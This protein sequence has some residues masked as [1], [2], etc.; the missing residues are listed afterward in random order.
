MKCR[1]CSKQL[2]SK[3]LDLGFAPHS[4]AYLSSSDLMRHEKYYPLQIYVCENCWLVQTVGETNCEELFDED[5]SYFSS[6]SKSWL[7]HASDYCSMIAKRLNLNKHSNVVEI[8]SNDGY[9]LKNFLQDNI[10]CYG[11]EP[12]KSTADA[13]RMLGIDVIQ[14]F[15]TEALAKEL[16]ISRGK[17]N[18]IIGNNVYA[19]VPDIRDFTRGLKELLAD[20]GTITLEFPHLL[21]LVIKNQFDTIYHEHYSYLSL[22]VVARIFTDAG[23]KII[24]VEALPTHGG[25][26]R[27]YGAHLNDERVVSNQYHEL[28]SCEETNCL[29]SLEA[30]KKLQ[31]EATRLKNELLFFLLECFRNNKKVFAYGAAAKGNTLLNFAGIKPDFLPFICDAAKSKQSKYMPGSHI[32]IIDPAEI[33]IQKPDYILILPWNISEEIIEQI[34]YIR[35]W[36]GI[37]VTLS[38][39]I[40]V[41]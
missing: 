17:A 41:C 3:V 8:A 16:A 9:L 29:G 38:P 6:T 32:P 26:I 1:Y 5:Y 25:S 30:Y 40:K 39:S 31:Y 35:E 37:F 20:G 7:K 34:S 27:V 22:A 14:S 33:K 4:N 10:P 15:F 28:L 18:L 13:S 19:H 23:L 11:I 21:N 24:D 2:N 12:T 36:G